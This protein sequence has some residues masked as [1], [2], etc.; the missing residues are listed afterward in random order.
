M[1][2]EYSNI[3]FSGAAPSSTNY[4]ESHSFKHYLHCL[5]SQCEQASKPTYGAS[6][7]AQFAQ[8]ET[9]AQ[10]LDGLHREKIKGQDRDFR[11]IVDVNEAAIQIFD[12]EFGFVMSQEWEN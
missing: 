3:L 9:A 6:R 2:N 10:I 8:L 1:A 7:D 5:K 12:K 11:E 4:K